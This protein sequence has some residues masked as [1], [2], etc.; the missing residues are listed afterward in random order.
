MGVV[1]QV[2][3][4]LAVL[5]VEPLERIF[6]VEL[7]CRRYPKA[8]LAFESERQKDVHSQWKLAWEVLPA[9]VVR[10]TV[11]A[12]D[13]LSVEDGKT[14]PRYFF[15]EWIHL[16]SFRFSLVSANSFLES[17]YSVECLQL[18][19]AEMNPLRLRLAEEVVAASAVEWL[20]S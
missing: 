4:A 19:A 11:V 14:L 6:C 20:P 7:E 3:V 10:R 2:A 18:D 5:Q 15:V 13:A 9:L 8:L 16:K 17:T 1:G 12:V